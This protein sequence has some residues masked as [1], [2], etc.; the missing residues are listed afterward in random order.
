MVALV[1]PY[2]EQSPRPVGSATVIR[3]ISLI[4]IERRE[5]AG[6]SNLA[7]RALMCLAKHDIPVRLISQ[8][9][10][11]GNICFV[12]SRRDAEAALD[13]LTCEL[14]HDLERRDVATLRARH[15]VLVISVAGPL[16]PLTGTEGF[17][18]ALQICDAL[19]EHGVNI[20]V[21]VQGGPVLSAASLVIEAAQA[22]S[23][24]GALNRLH[25]NALRVVS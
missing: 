11:A 9:S 5:I 19:A 24:L 2:P 21:F 16:R 20:L 6:F 1:Q 15:D 8:S 13:A 10:S 17:S 3:D 7:G 23:A 4:A 25:H 12:V 18:A 14:R 22:E